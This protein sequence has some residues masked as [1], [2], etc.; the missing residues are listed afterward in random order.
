[1]F[2]LHSPCQLRQDRRADDMGI[3]KKKNKINQSKNTN[4]ERVVLFSQWWTKMK[5]KKLFTWIQKVQ[6]PDDLPE[7]RLTPWW[8]Q[9]THTNTH[10]LPHTHTARG[11]G[12]S[13]AWSAAFVCVNDEQDSETG[14]WACVHVCACVCTLPRRE[15]STRKGRAGNLWVPLP[16][17]TPPQCLLN[18]NSSLESLGRRRKR[19]SRQTPH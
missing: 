14:L 11:D 12:E 17:V 2:T 7:L 3:F 19:S 9:S 15:A 13:T 10:A 5:K 18:Q 16:L 1:M 4:F 6:N 8:A